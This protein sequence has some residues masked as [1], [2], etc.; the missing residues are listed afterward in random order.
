MY[1]VIHLV[2]ITSLWFSQ[3]TET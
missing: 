3:R 2:F 1:I